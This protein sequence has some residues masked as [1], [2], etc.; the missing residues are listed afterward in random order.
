MDRN[1]SEFF[2]DLQRQGVLNESIVLLLSDHG[3]RFGHLRKTTQGWYEE[4]LP[5]N[6]ISVPPW[7]RKKYPRKYAN[8]KKNSKRLTSTFDMYMTLQ[9]I[10]A[11]SSPNFT[12]SSSKACPLCTSLFNDIPEHRSC[13]Q[14]G[15]PEVWC[16]CIGRFK[17]KTGT[18]ELEKQAS[19]LSLRHLI[20]T[21][22]TRNDDQDVGVEQITQSVCTSNKR[23][24][25]YMLMNFRTNENIT[26]QSLLRLTKDRK[27]VVK[28]L[29]IIRL[30]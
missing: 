29:N 12:I 10:L 11:M 22:M 21:R 26:Y 3:I 15:I 6:L 28:V 14:A 4:R 23:K 5:L 1:I 7:F 25:N 27:E 8:L 19:E 2:Q 16:T 24:K 13:K 9:D 17:V 20:E 18:L 30:Y